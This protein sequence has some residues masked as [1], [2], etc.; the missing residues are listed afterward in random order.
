M[1]YDESLKL[2]YIGIEEEIMFKNILEIILLLFV[3]IQSKYAQSKKKKRKIQKSM[4]NK[5]KITCNPTV[6]R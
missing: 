6:Q 4:K 2:Y 1:Y 5:I 3:I